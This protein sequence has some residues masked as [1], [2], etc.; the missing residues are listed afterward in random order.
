M[1]ASIIL[2]FSFKYKFLYVWHK[3]LFTFQA[4][5]ACSFFL[6]LNVRSIKSSFCTLTRRQMSCVCRLIPPLFPRLCVY[7]TLSSCRKQC[8]NMYTL[9]NQRFN[10]WTIKLIVST[11]LKTF[12][13]KLRIDF[14]FFKLDY[15]ISDVSSS[16]KK[17]NNQIKNSFKSY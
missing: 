11:N 3:F 14:I 5:D 4:L 13:G 8:S 6:T 9:V 10:D 12:F 7:Q 16:L 1:F 2:N 17:R 15:Q